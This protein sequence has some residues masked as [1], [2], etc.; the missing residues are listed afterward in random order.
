MAAAASRH[1]AIYQG[2]HRERIKGRASR[3]MK[4]GHCVGRRR[5]F[6][7]L[8]VLRFLVRLVFFGESDL[9]LGCSRYIY[10]E[11]GRKSADAKKNNIYESKRK[12]FTSRYMK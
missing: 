10:V 7:L 2:K 6:G 5:G 9:L 11:G 3:R 1:Y 4:T 12:V 8:F